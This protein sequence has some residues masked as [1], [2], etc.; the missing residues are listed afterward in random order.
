MT[1][2]RDRHQGTCV[3]IWRQLLPDSI[4][5]GR[6][7]DIFRDSQSSHKGL[8]RLGAPSVCKHLLSI[9]GIEWCCRKID[10]YVG[11]ETQVP[12]TVQMKGTVLA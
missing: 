4:A 8:M 11:P 7:S 6:S 10:L 1:A 9:P 2:E 5:G 3:T 12:N